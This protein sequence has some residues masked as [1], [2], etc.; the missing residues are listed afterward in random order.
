MHTY[1]GYLHPLFSLELSGSA[2]SC[3]R[4][5]TVFSQ[6]WT[7]SVH[8]LPATRCTRVSLPSTGFRSSVVMTLRRIKRQHHSEAI[9]RTVRQERSRLCFFVDNKTAS[10][11]SPRNYNVI[12]VCATTVA[13]RLFSGVTTF[14]FALSAIPYV[15]TLQGT[16]LQRSFPRRSNKEKTTQLHV[17]YNK[18]RH[19][20]SRRTRTAQRKASRRWL[21]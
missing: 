8:A 13:N 14:C 7:R 6:R 17:H 2:G 1:L 10:T 3:S 9:I 16:L 12:E 18:S 21:K 11:I 15:S 19:T 5:R 4:T 20:A